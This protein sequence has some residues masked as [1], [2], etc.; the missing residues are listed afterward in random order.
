MNPHGPL[1][2]P[3]EAVLP[4]GLAPSLAFGATSRYNG[5]P[6]ATVEVDG[7]LVRYVT[8][9]F[10]PAPDRFAQV[11]EHVVAE[12]ERHD[13]LAAALDGDPEQFWRLCDANGVLDPEELAV[14][15]RRVRVVLPEGVPPVA[16]D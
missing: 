2:D 5:L 6:L 10:V 3:T 11:G 15:G 14:V 8:R 9:R 7:R 1:R 16:G 4:G 13:T 12:G